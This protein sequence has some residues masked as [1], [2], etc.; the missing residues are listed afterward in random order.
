MNPFEHAIRALM[1]KGFSWEG[2]YNNWKCLQALRDKH[3]DR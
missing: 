2:A 3:A 1:A